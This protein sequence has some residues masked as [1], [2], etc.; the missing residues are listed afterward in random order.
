MQNLVKTGMVAVLCI[1]LSQQASAGI[2]DLRK[3]S[4]EKYAK[5]ECGLDPY[6][7]YAVA[8]YDSRQSTGEKGYIAPSP[9]ALNNPVYGSYYPIN[10]ADAKRALAR[11]LAASPVTDIGISQINYRWNGHYV[12]KPEDL[13]DVDINIRVGAKVLCN[14]IDSMPNDIVL[15][16][17]S[18]HTPNPA[19]RDKARN[20][21]ENVLRIWKRLI[22]NG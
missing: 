14:A 15:A 5:A 17:G 7:L 20:Y 12:N 19:L 3:T 2:I 8:L 4:W 21:G 13:L 22:E 9:W 10:Y 6:L 18:Y 16:I 1:S 11:Y